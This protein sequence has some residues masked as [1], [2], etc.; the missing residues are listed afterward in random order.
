M[1]KKLNAKIDELT[2]SQEP[3]D[4]SEDEADSAEENKGD[5]QLKPAK[6]FRGGDVKGSKAKSNNNYFFYHGTKP[7]Y[8]VAAFSVMV[9]EIFHQLKKFNRKTLTVVLPDALEYLTGSDADF[10]GIFSQNAE[11]CEIDYRGNLMKKS[12]AVIFV[13]SEIIPQQNHELPTLTYNN[14]EE[15]AE[16]AYDL[17]KN[18]LG[19]DEVEICRDQTKAQIIDKFGELKADAAAFE[20]THTPQTI[21]SQAVVWIGFVIQ[22]DY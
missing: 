22:P 21:F 5:T 6:G 8:G 15:R 2:Q 16:L 14:S 4:L 13:N 18:V 1:V 12:R 7:E 10:E 9:N 19:Y 20:K 17:F 11:K 3:D